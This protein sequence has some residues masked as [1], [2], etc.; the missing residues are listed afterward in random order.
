M[1]TLSLHSYK[2]Q[3]LLGMSAYWCSFTNESNDRT[4]EINQGPGD[5]V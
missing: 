3:P 5:T 4:P 1:Q 2:Q